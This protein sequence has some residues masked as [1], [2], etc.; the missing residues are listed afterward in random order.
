MGVGGQRH[1]LAAL[2]PGKTRCLLC[3]RLGG[4]P[5]PV[6]TDKENLSPT[7]IRSPDRPA[8]SESIYR[9]SYRG[10]WIPHKITE[11]SLGVPCGRFEFAIHNYVGIR[12]GAL[13]LSCAT[14]CLG[15]SL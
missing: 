5:G 11:Y 15:D 7:G 9:L 8:L 13:N 3:R 4:P 1:A 10:P 12:A 2:P 6:W 14:D